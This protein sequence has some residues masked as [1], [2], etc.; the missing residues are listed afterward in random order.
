MRISDWLIDVF[1]ADGLTFKDGRWDVQHISPSFMT[2]MQVLD[3]RSKLMLSKWAT[4]GGFACQCISTDIRSD[5]IRG[6]EDHLS[7]R[8]SLINFV[9]RR[10]LN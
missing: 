8:N 4:T 2:S 6:T 10:L 1:I 9:R 7:A 3:G 5:K